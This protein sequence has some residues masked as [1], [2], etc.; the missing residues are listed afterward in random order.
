MARW[1]WLLQQLGR[2][3][4]LRVSLFALG[5]VLTALVGV[6]LPPFLPDDLPT[7]LGP[8]AIDGILEILASSMLAVTTF[9]L[10]TMVTAYGAATSNATPRATRLMTDDPTTQNALGT[11]IGSFIF[12]LVG[13]IALST[14]AYGEKGRLILFLAT[15]A[16]V[17]LIV[18]TLLRW[19]DYL[20]R[21]GRVGETVDRVAAAARR[22]LDDRA[23]NPHLGGR[24]LADWRSAV[25]VGSTPLHPTAIGY[26]QHIDMP[27]L[28]AC[29]AKAGG[30]VYVLTLPGT[31][32]D[33]GRPLAH[34]D[35]ITE[36][37]A[38]EAARAAFTIGGARSFDQDPRFGICVLAEIASRALS[39]GINDPGTAIDVIGTGVQTLARWADQ[40]KA[41]EPRYAAVLVPALTVDDLFDDFF[42]PIARDGAALVE[43]Q[44]RLQ[45]ALAILAR[46]DPARFGAAAR[47]HAGLALARAERALVLET[48]KQLVRQAAAGLTGAAAAGTEPLSPAPR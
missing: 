8:D 14:E 9:S 41:A 2:R 34:L 44:L 21:L 39:P 20:T 17:G 1:Q 40:G 5:A 45:K 22:A 48:E 18:V 27:A 28:E 13:L 23:A 43:I 47:R 46:A 37:E 3:L 35:G 29:A 31:F 7:A 6:V 12:S 38:I 25:L 42:S 16:L 26:V 4:W 36:D 15:L 33:P 24:P 19:I 32:V 30:S 10:A 11:F